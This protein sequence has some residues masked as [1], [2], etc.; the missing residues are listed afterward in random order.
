MKLL[1]FDNNPKIK[2]RLY[3]R[4]KRIIDA[5]LDIIQDKKIID[6]A[7]NNGRWS[8][9]AVEAGA[10][11]VHSIEGRIDKVA[12]AKAH[13]KRLDVNDKIRTNTGDLYNWLYD[14]QRIN[15]DTIFCLGIFYHITDH[16]HLLKLM[17]RTNAKSI[18]IDSGFVRSFKNMVHIQAENPKLHRNALPEFEDQ[19]QELVG[20]ISLGML[21]QLSWNLGYTCRPVSWNPKEVEYKNEVQDYMM[22][23][24]YT[25]RLDKMQHFH[26]SNWQSYWKDELVKI[27]PKFSG[28][29][30]KTTHDSVSDDRQRSSLR[31]SSITIY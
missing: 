26:D 22:G 10:Q 2:N 23:R 30:D 20:F 4:K 7:S 14:N 24:R 3:E 6:I 12:E 18:I 13:F 21:I 28:L 25:V 31:N 1:E 29:F 17:A 9:A 8:F 5:N 27:N 16:Y 19:E 15:V 11:L